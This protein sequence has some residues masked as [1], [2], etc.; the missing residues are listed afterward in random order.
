MGRDLISELKL[1]FNFNTKI[2]SWH[3]ID[4]SIKLQGGVFKQTT[5]YENIYSASLSPK[6]TVLEG[7]YAEACEPAHISGKL[8]FWMLIMKQ[9]I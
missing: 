3:N 8:K 9:Q 2:I 7:L 1:V 5:H 6:S 4:Q